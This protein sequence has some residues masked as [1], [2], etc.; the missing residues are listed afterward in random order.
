[1]LKENDAKMKKEIY[2]DH[3]DDLIGLKNTKAPKESNYG[4]NYSKLNFLYYLNRNSYLI[5][6]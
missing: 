4:E 3:I 5:Y 6:Y 2:K 1:M